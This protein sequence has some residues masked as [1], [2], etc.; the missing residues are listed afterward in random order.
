MSVA[1]SDGSLEGRSGKVNV[2]S[3]DWMSVAIS[4]GSLEGLE[5]QS[6]RP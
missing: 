1:I 3:I 6:R 2:T 4:D 5:R